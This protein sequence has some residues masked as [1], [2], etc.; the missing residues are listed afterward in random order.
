MQEIQLTTQNHVIAK[1]QM[2]KSERN[3]LKCKN[4]IKPYSMVRVTSFGQ[5]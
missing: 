1:K 4:I 3:Q 2:Y 5:I